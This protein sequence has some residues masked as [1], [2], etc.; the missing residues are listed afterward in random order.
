MGN[1][2]LFSKKNNLNRIEK[3]IIFKNNARQQISSDMKIFLYISALESFF[4]TS[5][6]EI[7]YQ[8]S[9]RCAL[10]LSNQYEERLQI[11]KIIKDAYDVRSHVVHGATYK[12]KKYSDESLKMMSSKLDEYIRVL[13]NEKRDLFEKNDEELTHFFNKLILNNN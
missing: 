3:A 5:K 8:V 11:Q 9:Q 13:L 2:N 4:N 12:S 1:L 6:N 10:L 7:T